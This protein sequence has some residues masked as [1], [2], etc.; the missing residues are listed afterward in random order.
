MFVTTVILLTIASALSDGEEKGILAKEGDEYSVPTCSDDSSFTLVD[1]LV[2]NCQCSSS[3][4]GI[5]S[6]LSSNAMNFCS[7]ASRCGSSHTAADFLNNAC[8][9]PN[10][11]SGRSLPFFVTFNSTGDVDSQGCATSAIPSTCST[12]SLSSPSLGKGVCPSFCA[13]G[14]SMTVYYGGCDI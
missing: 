1:L 10:D 13:S 11:N 2:G 7:G 3:E 6:L 12:M 4:A 8:F 5:V 9:C 14:S